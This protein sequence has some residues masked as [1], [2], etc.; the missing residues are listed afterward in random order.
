MDY[1]FGDEGS[2]R[3]LDHVLI[4]TLPP[5]PTAPAPGAD[6]EPAPHALSVGDYEVLLCALLRHMLG[7]VGH[8]AHV[9]IRGAHSGAHSEDDGE[10]GDSDDAAGQR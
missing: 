10:G 5:H 7:P 4:L 1:E 3:C 6:A 2:Q 9:D 8:V